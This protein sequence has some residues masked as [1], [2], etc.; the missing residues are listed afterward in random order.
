[1][2]SSTSSKG[3]RRAGGCGSP[4]ARRGPQQHGLEAWKTSRERKTAYK[5]F[6][7]VVS[8]FFFSSHRAII[9]PTLL[10]F[11]HFLSERAEMLSAVQSTQQPEIYE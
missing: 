5:R 11:A 4:D 7:G 1:M 9:G 3:R 2:S 10:F 8:G 6:S